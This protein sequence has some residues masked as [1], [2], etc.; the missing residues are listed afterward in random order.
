[1]TRRI[2]DVQ[3]H[4]FPTGKIQ[5]RGGWSRVSNQGTTFSTFHQ[6]TEA[7]LQQPTSYINDNYNAGVSFRV[8]P[9]TSFNYDQ[10]YTF[11]KGDTTAQLAPAGSA[12]NFGVPTFSLANGAPVSLGL[13]FNTAAS[14]PCAAPVLVTGLANNSCNGYTGYSRFGP[15]RNSYWTEQFSVQTNYWPRVDFA[16]RVVY[17]SAESKM[18]N[19]G[20]FFSGLETRTATVMQNIVSPQGGGANSNRLSL[21]TDFGTT[22]RVTDRFHVI[23]QFRYTNFRIPGNWLYVTN[24]FFAPLLGS[25]PNMFSPANCPTATSAGCPQ[26][27]S[28]SGA[29]MITDSLSNFLRQSYTLN[30]FEFE[31]EFTR[32][33]SGYI[34]YRFGQRNISLINTDNQVSVFYP[35]LPNRG[36]C[37]GQ[38]LINGICTVATVLEAEDTNVQINAQ[39]ALF[40]LSARPTDQWRLNGDVELLSADNAFTRISPRHLQLYRAKANYRPK[41]TIDLG[42]ALYIRE[43]RNTAADIGNLQH[44]RSYSLTAA[45]MPSEAKWGV[46]ASYTYNDIFSQTN[47]CFVSTPTPPGALS[48]GTS[49]LISGVS[50]YDETTNFGSASVTLKPMRRVAANVGYTITSSNGSTLILNPIAPTGPL[51]YNYQVPLAGVAI[52]LQRHLLFKTGWNYYDYNEDSAPGPTLPRNFRGNV[53][54]LS[55]RYIM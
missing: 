34:G 2:S 53:F 39:S 50:T 54:T 41:E 38:P 30:T 17:S 16:G 4:L 13:V 46:D 6:G 33:A 31:Y 23:D 28:S 27:T 14:Q 48:C 9:R 21:T 20:S 25:V 19:F 10:F 43:N 22:V 8:I 29:D 49:L 52:E 3:M 1:M 7:L 51:T 5:L 11:F 12:A 55:M 40:G 32:R 35:T 45:Y 18:P 44:N 24:S 42:A 26:H 37:A 47:I 36:A 15:V